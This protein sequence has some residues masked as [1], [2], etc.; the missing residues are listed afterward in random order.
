MNM[1]HDADIARDPYKKCNY[2]LSLFEGAD[3]EGWIQIHDN[4]LE[5]VT[6]DRTILPWRMNE[7]QVTEREFKK[8]F[9]DYAESEK[10]NDKLRKLKMKDGN[11]DTYIARF[12]QLAHQGG[13]NPNEPE[14]LRLFGQGLPQT[15]AHKCLELNQGL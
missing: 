9:I 15:L 6:Y 3:T 7:W 5:A 12:T 1:N 11:V 10:A 8:A 13:H 4:W 14:L 2:F